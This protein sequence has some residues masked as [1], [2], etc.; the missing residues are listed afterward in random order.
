MTASLVTLSHFCAHIKNC[1][2]INLAKTAV[3]YTRTNLQAALQLYNQ[4]FISG[5]QRGSTT[6]PDLIPTDAT[7]DNISTRRLW[8][9]LKYR[10]NAPVISSLEMVSKPSK[11]IY[12]SADDIKALASSLKVR[13]VDPIQPAECLFIEHKQDIYEVNEAAEKGLSGRALFRVR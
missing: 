7:P 2:N 5:I 8:I 4:G 11:K 3:P 13:R 6:G 10:N 12:L 1:L 9:D